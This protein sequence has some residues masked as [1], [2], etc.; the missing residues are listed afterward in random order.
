MEAAEE[1]EPSAVLLQDDSERDANI[2]TDLHS[3]D[4]RTRTKLLSKLRVVESFFRVAL[5]EDGVRLVD[6]PAGGF[7]AVPERLMKTFIS[8]VG[9][10]GR[11]YPPL[12]TAVGP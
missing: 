3:R 4:A 5:G 11:F 10:Q 7:K 9:K 1:Y 6:E 8:Q 2:E 12:W